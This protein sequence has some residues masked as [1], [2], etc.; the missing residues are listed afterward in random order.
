MKPLTNYRHKAMIPFS[1]MP[2]LAYALCSLPEDSEV[3]MVV[4]HLREQFSGYFGDCFR[5]RKIKYLVQTNPAGTG[6]ALV[7]FFEAYRPR[8]PVIVWQADQMIFPDEVK[9]LAGS[10]PN[11]A[12][13]SDTPAG[14][15]DLGFW[16]IKPET[17]PKLKSHFERG[18]YRALPALQSEGLKPIRMPREKLEISF[19]ALDQIDRTCRLY[20]Q[21]FHIAS[22]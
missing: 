11:A 12:I 2:F 17:L 18:E 9:N 21:K 7:Q 13:Y 15:K 6:D 5:G 14:L 4:N 20:R 1:G 22:R 8:Q 16:K 19:D 3:V 10:E